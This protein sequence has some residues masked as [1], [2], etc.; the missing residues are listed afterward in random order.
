[1]ELPLIGSVLLWMGDVV[2]VRV[3][4]QTVFHQVDCLFRSRGL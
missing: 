3:A 1:M 2:V 4:V